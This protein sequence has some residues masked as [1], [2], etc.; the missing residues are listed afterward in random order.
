M[1]VREKQHKWGGRRTGG[2][3]VLLMNMDDKILRSVFIVSFFKR[4]EQ[5]GE[6]VKMHKFH[7]GRE[8]RC[9]GML[10]CVG[11][12]CLL[13]RSFTCAPARAN[14]PSCAVRDLMA[15]INECSHTVLRGNTAH[16]SCPHQYLWHC[17]Q[18]G[19]EFLLGAWWGSLYR[20]FCLSRDP[21]WWNGHPSVELWMSHSGV[22][23][24]N[25]Q[26]RHPQGSLYEG[27]GRKRFI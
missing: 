19:M 22:H 26:Y 11:Q 18:Q 9:W 25:N 23:R 5:R 4:W 14:S 2:T 7:A 24:L 17:S 6:S 10:L 13:G 8:G 16:L 21:S 20:R 12:H 1:G 3:F 15:G 27:L